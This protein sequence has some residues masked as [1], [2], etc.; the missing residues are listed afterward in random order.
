LEYDVF[1]CYADIQQM[2]MNVLDLLSHP[3]CDDIQLRQDHDQNRR[4]FGEFGDG[5]DPGEHLIAKSVLQ[6]RIVKNQESPWLC[7]VRRGRQAGRFKTHENLFPLHRLVD[8]ASNAP[9]PLDNSLKG[10]FSICH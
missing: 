10:S 5:I 8:I 1:P 7:I 4:F 3:V 2:K 6:I 9:A